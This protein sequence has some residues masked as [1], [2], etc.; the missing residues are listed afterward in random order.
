MIERFLIAHTDGAVGQAENVQLKIDFLKHVIEPAHGL[1][2]IH[3]YQRVGKI[4]AGRPER[5]VRHK[6]DERCVEHAGL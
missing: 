4:E 5:A 3:V 6:L 2:N 1:N